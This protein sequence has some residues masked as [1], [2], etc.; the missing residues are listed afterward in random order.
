MMNKKNELKE[1]IIS[2]NWSGNMI[3]NR[4]GRQVSPHKEN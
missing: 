1:I 2:N 4:I 3:K